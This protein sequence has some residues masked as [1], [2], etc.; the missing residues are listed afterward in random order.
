[1]YYFISQRMKNHLFS[2]D[3]VSIPKY[4]KKKSLSLEKSWNHHVQLPTHPYHIHI[5]QC[6]ISMFLHVSHQLTLPGPFPFCSFPAT[7]P[8]ACSSARGCDQSAGAS[9]WLCWSSYSW[10]QP[11]DPAYPHLSTGSFYPQADQHF[12]PVWCHLQTY[13][14]CTQSPHPDH[15]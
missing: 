14:W 9:P 10:P 15:Q 2:L 7:L 5:P 1:M 11:I 12:L 4:K 3:Q 6:H 13:W 8:Q